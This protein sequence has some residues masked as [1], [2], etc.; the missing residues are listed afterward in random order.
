MSVW[1][2]SCSET[3]L[4]RKGV[5]LAATGLALSAFC[6]LAPAHAATPYM[7]IMPRADCA[8]GDRT[9]TGLQ[10]QTTVAERQSGASK[11]AYNCNLQL[12][13]QSTGEGAEYQMTWSDNCAYYA[14]ANRATQAHRG[15]AVVDVTDPQNP[16]ATAYLNDP[17]MADPWESLKVNDRRKLLG[18]VQGNGGNGT[19]SGF[20]LYDIAAN[21]A[22]PQPLSTLAL[23]PSAPGFVR[24]HA[25]DFSPDG[26][27]FYGTD[28]GRSVIYPIDI[29]DP[30]QPRLLA[31]WKAPD[32]VGF[33]HD[34]TVNED[35]TRLYIA[36]PR[37]APNGN[38]LVILDV[39]DVQN[40]VP[41]PQFRVVSKL[42]WT[43]SAEAQ[44]AKKIRIKGRP[45]I[46]ISDEIGP[47]GFTGTRVATACAQNIPSYGLARIIDI[48]DET[49]PTL[50]SQLKLE[51]HDPA[52]CALFMPDA[53]AG[54]IYDSHYCTTDDPKNAKMAACSWF[55]SGIRI[56]DIRDPYHPK[57]LA[58]YKPGAVGTASRPGST[59]TGNRTWDLSSSNIRWVK[60]DGD[61]FLW[62]TSHDNGFQVVKF[63]D[64][65]KQKQ[66]A[67]FQ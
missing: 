32:G 66:P 34:I 15:V 28:R 60:K 40:R 45:Y 46:L 21:C 47:G 44:V 37:I 59:L 13:G 1:E 36:Q 58:Y 19:A 51:V 38:G 31:K 49:N 12:V 5:A 7:G 42:Y 63:S 55:Q 8:P 9:E 33:P 20:A 61:I 43:D 50:V 23:E 2:K 25:G 64:Y 56:I 62:F 27:T 10:G 52:N 53:T 11:T 48:L 17:S 18:A 24:G 35:G 3:R 65:L 57:E 29:S 67:L 14:T 41:D 26:K 4:G 54:F 30:T 22:N 16:T 6:L 39:S